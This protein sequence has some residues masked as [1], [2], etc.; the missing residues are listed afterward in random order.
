MSKNNW[1]KE[2]QIIA[3]NIMAIY[4]KELQGYFTLPLAYVIAGIFWLL[5]GY[6]LVAL[7]LGGEGI[8]QQLAT[9]DQLGITKPPI[10]AAYEFLKSY[11]SVMGSLSLFILPM[12]SMGLYTEERKRGT[13]ELL[14][15]SPITN[16][17]V[18]VGKLAGVLTF[19]LTI[20]SPIML[21]ES[22]VITA[23][24]PPVSPHI[25]ILG[26]VGLILLAGGILSLGMFVSSLTDSTVLAAILTFALVLF[27]WIIDVLAN[28]IGGN[29]GESLRHLSL[30]NNYQNMMK[31]I[32]DFSSFIMFISY[33]ILGIFLTAQSVDASRFQRS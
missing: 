22:M 32:F 33:M 17:A 19:Y 15:T 26:N 3:N 20:M 12:L 16:W 13:L 14:A 11:F 9:R 8:I 27:L 7:L 21:I 5:A 23:T 31:G 6:F 29:I 18:A 4:C 28:A 1:L 30:L 2:I 25:L 24:N 10:D